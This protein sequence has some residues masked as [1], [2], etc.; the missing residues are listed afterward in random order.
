MR[1]QG[2]RNCRSAGGWLT[3]RDGRARLVTSGWLWAFSALYTFGQTPPTQLNLEDCV[4]LAQ[5][6]PS[7]VRLARQQ[8]EIARYGITQARAGFLPQFSVG[9]SYT[10][11]SPLLYDRSTASF[12]PLNG[13]REYSSLATTGVEFD[14]SGRLRAGMDRARADRDAANVNLGLSERDLKRAV[15]AS[16]YHV[17]LTRNL[18]EAARAN[19]TEARAFE[20]R[21]RRLTEGG[22]ASQADLI[23]A[24][25][26]VVIL[27]QAQQ[28]LELEARLANHDLASFWTAD[29]DTLLGL[30]DVMGQPLPAPEAPTVAAPFLRRI[31]FN[32]FDAQQRGFLADSRRARAE[33]RPRTSLVFQYG[34][35]AQRVSINNRGYAT[36]I[37]LDVPV[38][39]W[40]RSRSASQ[41]FQLQAQQVG[42]TRQIAERVFSKEY[43]D[44]LARVQL[45]YAQIASTDAQVKLSEDNLRLSRVRYEGGEGPALD[46]VAAQAQLV[47]VRNNYYAVRASYLNA[48]ADLEVARGQ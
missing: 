35:D 33:L 17:L 25:S 19:L 12:L 20:D 30:V 46:V 22:E 40:F 31:E 24:S 16:Y 39:D 18:V 9:N 38:F 48:R 5:S 2:E 34:I 13:I 11:N 21:V 7:S 1:I 6:A 32:L 27:D 42:T 45:I 41:Q 29:V 23:K 44:A 28:A 47:Q 15:A 26:Q 14:T 8:T 36:F 10:Y 4:R 3:L 37:R 43:Q